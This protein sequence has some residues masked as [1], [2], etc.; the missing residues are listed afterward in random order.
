MG[1]SRQAPS[2]RVQPRH[3]PELAPDTAGV[4]QGKRRRLLAPSDSIP[5]FVPDARVYEERRPPDGEGS[6]HH[7]LV[8]TLVRGPHIRTLAGGALCAPPPSSKTSRGWT[9]RRL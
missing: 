4:C 7:H 9:M 8:P 6:P 1:R 3:A 5:L 2:H